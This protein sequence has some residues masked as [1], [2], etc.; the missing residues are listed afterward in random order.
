MEEFVECI[1]VLEQLKDV[2]ERGVS[3]IAVEVSESSEESADI[4]TG[5]VCF[6][7]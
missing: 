2:W 5:T 3:A 6:V 4:S 7:M 1:E